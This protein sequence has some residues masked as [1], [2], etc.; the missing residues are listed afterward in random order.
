MLFRSKE[1]TVWGSFVKSGNG[2]KT[3]G[4]GIGKA[5]LP[6]YVGA[7]FV[8][9]T[10]GSKDYKKAAVNST[11][12]AATYIATMPL[13]NVARGFYPAMATAGPIGW[14][15]IA[16]IE[17]TNLAAALILSDKIEPYVGKAFDK[18]GGAINTAVSYYKEKWNKLFSKQ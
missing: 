13:M 8:E 7:M 10:F 9:A 4:K 11:A 15:G 1:A 5:A 3:L 6:L 17:V 16:A 12:F 18:T 2:L 14:A